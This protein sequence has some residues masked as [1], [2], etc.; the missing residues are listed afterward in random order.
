[1]DELKK[2]W[3]L[4][5]LIA[6][7]MVA[8]VF[9]YGLVAQVIGQSGSLPG[10]SGSKEQAQMLR[11]ILFA[12]AIGDSLFSF[13]IK[14]F[15]LAA[16]AGTP[17]KMREELV[18]IVLAQKLQVS[19]IVVLAFCESVA[20]IGLVLFFL[21]GNTADFYILLGLS[22]ALFALHFPRFSKWQEFISEKQMAS[23][24]SQGKI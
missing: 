11:L 23:I 7:A 10:Y 8:S 22:L 16:G 1:M 24:I 12:V 9:I 17:E 18:V 3:Q 2:R 5:A 14:R 21:T 4:T 13:L 6:A 20:I 19:T 15:L